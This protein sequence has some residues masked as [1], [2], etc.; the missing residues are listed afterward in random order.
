M[1][2]F[3]EIVKIVFLIIVILAILYSISEGF[4][5]YDDQEYTKACFWMLVVLVLSI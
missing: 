2:A 5:A 4:D 1:I 3:I